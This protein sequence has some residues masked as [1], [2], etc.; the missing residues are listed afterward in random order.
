MATKEWLMLHK[1]EIYVSKPHVYVES[2]VY[3]SV[4]EAER[5]HVTDLA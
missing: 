1:F 5:H 4:L 3:F 2:Q